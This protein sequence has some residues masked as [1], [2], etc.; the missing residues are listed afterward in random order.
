[1][2]KRYSGASLSIIYTTGLVL[3]FHRFNRENQFI[4][5]PILSRFLKKHQR[6]GVGK[7]AA[8]VTGG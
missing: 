4:R 5:K 1:L 3:L 2:G 7:K 6:Q 8:S